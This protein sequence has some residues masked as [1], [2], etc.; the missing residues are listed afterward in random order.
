MLFYIMAFWFGYITF[1]IDMMSRLRDL[2]CITLRSKGHCTL[3]ETLEFGSDPDL[4]SLFREPKS[5]N[6]KHHSGNNTLVLT[7]VTNLWHRSHDF[8][9]CESIK[10]E[11]KELCTSEPSDTYFINQM[12]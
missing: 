6:Y 12:C 7:S 3:N 1:Q 8:Q 4:I 5:K 2:C 9:P 10:Q 11:V